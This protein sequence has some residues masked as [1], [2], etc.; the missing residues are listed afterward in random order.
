MELN[1][2]RARCGLTTHRVCRIDGS[3]CVCTYIHMYVHMHVHIFLYFCTCIHV[4]TFM[5]IYVYIY[6]CMCVYI[7]MYIYIYVYIPHVINMYT[8][9]YVCTYTHERRAETLFQLDG[10]SKREA[11]GWLRCRTMR[12]PDAK[13]NSIESCNESKTTHRQIRLFKSVVISSSAVIN[14]TV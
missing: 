2:K 10:K 5:W 6:I 3:T 14:S 12:R 11:I 9:V 13:T 4:N 1:L 8:H 7:Y